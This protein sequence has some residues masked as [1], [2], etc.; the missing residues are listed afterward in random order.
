MHLLWHTNLQLVNQVFWSC[1]RQLFYS[2]FRDSNSNNLEQERPP[3]QKQKNLGKMINKKKEVTN[4]AKA[5]KQRN[6][7]RHQNLSHKSLKTLFFVVLQWSPQKVVLFLTLDV[8]LKLTLERLKRG[9]K[10]NS[11]AHI[12]ITHVPPWVW[13]ILAISLGHLGQNKKNMVAWCSWTI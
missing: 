12:Y 8:V 5:R 7:I 9:T 3:W 10:T 4:W 1:W 13:D 6:T 11:P 2:V